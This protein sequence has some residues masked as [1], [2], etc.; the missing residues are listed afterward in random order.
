MLIGF[1]PLILRSITRTDA[2]GN[3]LSEITDIQPNKDK[4]MNSALYQANVAF[5]DGNG[6]RVIFNTLEELFF[7]ALKAEETYRAELVFMQSKPAVQSIPTSTNGD[8]AINFNALD[9]AVIYQVQVI[10]NGQVVYEGFPSGNFEPIHLSENGNYEARVRASK[11]QQIENGP[12]SLWSD[13]QSFAVDIFALRQIT[14]APT[15]ALD[16]AGRLSINWPALQNTRIYEVQL[17][18]DPDFKTID[19]SFW[20]SGSHEEITLP[21]DGSFFVRV[22]AWSELPENSGIASQFFSFDPIVFAKPQAQISLL[23]KVFTAFLIY[24]PTVQGLKERAFRG[25]ESYLSAW[26]EH[27]DVSDLYRF[28]WKEEKKTKD[29]QFVTT[30]KEPKV[31]N[32]NE[33]LI[34]EDK[35]IEQK[36]VI[37]GLTDKAEVTIAFPDQVPPN[38]SIQFE[39]ITLVD[40]TIPIPEGELQQ[41]QEKVRK[42]EISEGLYLEVLEQ[43]KKRLDQT[44]Q[45]QKPALIKPSQTTPMAQGENQIPTEG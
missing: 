20:P 30:A 32:L 8:V 34:P 18:K 12:L 39:N 43:M 10:K 15:P 45:A 25:N 41:M 44:T 6:V 2:D 19:Q 5:P 9:G 40:S 35:N 11:N 7:Q 22:R 29:E 1:G 31:K 36:D 14:D 28:W 27:Q 42:E 3:P 4:G 33:I 24:N 38:F 13:P 23:E 17:S 26:G 16:S 37:D 21:N